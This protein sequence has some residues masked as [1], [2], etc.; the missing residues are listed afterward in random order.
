MEK[1]DIEEY[2]RQLYGIANRKGMRANE[3]YVKFMIERFPEEFSESYMEEWAGRFMSGDVTCY[4]DS[5]SLK[6]Y[7]RLIKR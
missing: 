2:R 3:L 4:M 1:R 6:I 7:L 5:D